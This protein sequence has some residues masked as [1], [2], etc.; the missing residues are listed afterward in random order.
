MAF[1]RQLA[2]ALLILMS[3][4]LLSCDFGD[5]SETV[6]SIKADKIN[7]DSILSTQLE[8]S[9]HR[10]SVIDRQGVRS[11]KT[12]YEQTCGYCHGHGIAPIILGR[13][14]PEELT[15]VLV[16][17]GLNTMPAFRETDISDTELNNVAAW[18]KE[19]PAADLGVNG[20]QQ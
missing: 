3:F 4:L 14:L 11:G 16:R 9:L 20:R 7:S 18:I 8:D 1:S 2:S 19:S 15:K 5:V 10:F 12:V 6:P 13:Q 17:Q